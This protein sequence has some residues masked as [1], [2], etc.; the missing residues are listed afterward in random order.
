MM[1]SNKMKWRERTKLI[2]KT[3]THIIMDINKKMHQ[4][5]LHKYK[6]MK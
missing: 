6:L 4:T 1:K 2:N 5:K 3:R